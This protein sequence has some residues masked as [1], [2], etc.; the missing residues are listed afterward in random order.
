M[1]LTD[2]EDGCDLP[3]GQLRQA[4]EP[5]TGPYWPPLHSSHSV[6]PAPLLNFPAA[7]SVQLLDSSRLEIFP[8]GQ[9]KQV[10]DSSSENVPAGHEE[11]ALA[12]TPL[13]LPA[14]Q[15]MQAALPPVPY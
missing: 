9:L 6:P 5:A 11:H 12:A 3:L 15:T 2:S 14:V 10:L 4:M 8:A 1:Q 13:I 7:Q